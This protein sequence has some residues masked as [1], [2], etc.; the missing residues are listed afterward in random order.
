[1]VADNVMHTLISPHVI[2]AAQLIAMEELGMTLNIFVSP[3][4]ILTVNP[5]EHLQIGR[6]LLY[7]KSPY[8]YLAMPET[9]IF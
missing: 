7:L 5:T 9:Q 8:G 2:P 1:M 6:F 4:V 3:S